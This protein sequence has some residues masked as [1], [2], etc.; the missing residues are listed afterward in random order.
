MTKE[1][2]RATKIF[3]SLEQGVVSMSQL[4][5]A[6]H[7]TCV[8][9]ERAAHEQFFEGLV[10]NGTVDLQTI[11]KFLSSSGYHEDCFELRAGAGRGQ[12]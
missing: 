3:E 5:P 2:S 9:E 8:L 1:L 4:L 10:Q 12:H 6:K 7:L 11:L